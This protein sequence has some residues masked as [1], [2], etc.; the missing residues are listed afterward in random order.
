M[1]DATL[2]TIGE[3]KARAR[4]CGGTRS[5]FFYLKLKTL[6]ACAE[7]IGRRSLIVSDTGDTSD[8]GVPRAAFCANAR[9]SRGGYQ[10]AENSRDIRTAMHVYRRERV[11]FENSMHFS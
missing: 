4:A 5:F 3:H 8:T 6:P 10:N 11:T 7:T 2:S 1:P 9:N